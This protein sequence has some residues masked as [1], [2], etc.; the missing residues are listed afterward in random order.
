MV[1]GAELFVFKLYFRHTELVVVH[2]V[3]AVEVFASGSPLA[4]LAFEESVEAFRFEVSLQ[5]SQVAE[6]NCI[7][8]LMWTL[9]AQILTCSHVS[10]HLI[11]AQSLAWLRFLRLRDLW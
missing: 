6:T 10:N 8:I 9:E 4:V 11:K 3:E 5:L 2:F 1:F 7:A